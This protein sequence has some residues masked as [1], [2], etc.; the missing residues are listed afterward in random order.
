MEDDDEA[1]A[2]LLSEAEAAIA[3]AEAELAAA[4]TEAPRLEGVAAET[5]AAEQVLEK[6][7]N[8]NE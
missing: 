1:S 3:A 7:K 2:A 6:I 4:K 8:I 5:K